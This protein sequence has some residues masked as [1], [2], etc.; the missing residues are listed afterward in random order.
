MD[1]ELVDMANKNHM[2]YL[3]EMLDIERHFNIPVTY[4][5]VGCLLNEVREQISSGGHC[6]A[7]HSFDHNLNNE[8][9]FNCKEVDYRIKGYR[10]TQSK[11]TSELAIDNLAFNNFEWLAS[12]V[13]SLKINQ[14]KL[15]KGIVKIPIMFDDYPMYKDKISYK[16]WEN[17]AISA[18][19]EN[20]FVA[21]CLHDCYTKYWLSH[22]EDFINKIC[23]LGKFKTFN[24]VA[25]EEFLFNSL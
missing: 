16:D 14:P 7:F 23:N 4:N 19:E 21:F 24:Q 13:Y 18:I 15:E 10:T 25:Y 17:K 11:I 22:Y 20:D 8:Q 9:L 12:S 2:L 6:I 5:V 1:S 3:K